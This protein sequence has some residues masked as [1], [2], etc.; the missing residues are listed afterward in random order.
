MA[1]AT[2]GVL[3]VFVRRDG[4][5]TSS[6]TV[7]VFGAGTSASGVTDAQGKVTFGGLTMGAYRVRASVGQHRGEQHVTVPGGGMQTAVTVELGK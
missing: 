1:G 4:D 5:L 6:A 3:T 7:I 2:R